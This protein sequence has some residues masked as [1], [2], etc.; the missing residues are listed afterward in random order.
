[1]CGVAMQPGR[2]G[3]TT[4]HPPVYFTGD[5]PQKL[6]LVKKFPRLRAIRWTSFRSSLAAAGGGMSRVCVDAPHSAAVAPLKRREVEVFK[7]RAAG[8]RFE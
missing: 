8:L 4:R 3:C 2:R 6:F 7:A 5:S 1:M